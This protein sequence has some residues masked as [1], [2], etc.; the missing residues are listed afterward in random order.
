LPAAVSWQK[1]AREEG[2]GAGQE[3]S[4]EE[5]QVSVS[6]PPEWEQLRM[7]STRRR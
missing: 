1:E 2:Q 5:D 6:Q 4:R 3:S 7:T